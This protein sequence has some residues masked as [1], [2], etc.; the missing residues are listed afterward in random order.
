[1]DPRG[2]AAFR[3]RAHDAVARGRTVIYSTQ[4]LDVAERFSDLV[5]ILHQGK[6]VAFDS[7]DGLRDRTH[8]D[9]GVLEQIFAD[10]RPDA[11]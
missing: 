7:L 8:R 2:I 10:L 6:L 1:M 9:D 3:Q 4:I 11:P 5:A